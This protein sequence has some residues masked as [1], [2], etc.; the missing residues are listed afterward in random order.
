MNDIPDFPKEDELNLNRTKRKRE[1]VMDILMKKQKIGDFSSSRLLTS[2]ISQD[3]L[4]FDVIGHLEEE[5]NKHLAEYNGYYTEMLMWLSEAVKNE[6]DDLTINFHTVDKR[7]PFLQRKAV[8]NFLY[9][10]KKKGY[11]YSYKVVPKFEDDAFEDGYKCDVSY[12]CL[13][14]RLK[15]I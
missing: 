4:P 5:L 7:M 14:I 11:P 15:N 3:D 2:M 10:V 8:K 12:M 6:L 13:V 9:S 1:E